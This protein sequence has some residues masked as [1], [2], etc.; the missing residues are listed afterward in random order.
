MSPIA[1]RLKD[2]GTI[3][4][5]PSG[6]PDPALNGQSRTIACRNDVHWSVLFETGS[7]YSVIGAFDS[8]QARCRAGS[9]AW[10][11][12]ADFEPL[13]AFSTSDPGMID[14]QLLVACRLRGWTSIAV[15]LGRLAARLAPAEAGRE[16]AL[17]G[18]TCRRLGLRLILLGRTGGF[19]R[20]PVRSLSREYG[21]QRPYARPPV[22]APAPDR[23][24]RDPA[25]PRQ[26]PPRSRRGR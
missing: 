13:P 20:A 23:P 25:G 7:H 6:S 1:N 5:P 16:L 26:T 9:R 2:T 4:S 22:S 21:R 19:S 12:A 10:P 18:D 15:D 3:P 14:L 17:I 24:G 11:D 8:A